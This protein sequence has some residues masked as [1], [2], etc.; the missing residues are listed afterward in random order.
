MP[1]WNS[2]M[3]KPKQAFR[4][5]I[6]FGDRNFNDS[7]LATYNAIAE[8]AAKS[9]TKP[10]YTIKTN[11][12]KMLGS[13]AFLY[14]TNLSWQPISV[15]LVDITAFRADPYNLISVGDKKILNAG[16]PDASA[17]GDQYQFISKELYGE[18][19]G[20]YLAN[21]SIQQFFYSFLSDAGYVNPNEHSSD[22][23]LQRFRKSIFKQNTIGA[24]VGTNL[25]YEENG[26]ATSQDSWN[27]IKIMELDENGL[28]IET[29]DLYNPLI[30]KVSFGELS[31]ENENL[32]EISCE[33]SYDWAQL[34]PYNKSPNKDKY[35]GQLS[36][37]QNK[38]TASIDKQLTK[39]S[40]GSS[41]DPITKLPRVIPFVNNQD[42][43]PI[44]IDVND[45]QNLA[46][47]ELEKEQ[48]DLNKKTLIEVAIQENKLEA[49]LAKR[50]QGRLSRELDELEKQKDNLLKEAS[51]QLAIDQKQKEIDA[52]TRPA[53]NAVIKR[54]ETQSEEIR[55]QGDEAVE[56]TNDSQIKRT[57][58]TPEM[59]D[60][61]RR[62]AE[63]ATKTK[64]VEAKGREVESLRGKAEAASRSS[65]LET[66]Q[67]SEDAL[68]LGR[69]ATRTSRRPVT[70][71]EK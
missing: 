6:S 61:A 36:E 10:S 8:Y 43:T 55:K 59:A 28:V 49:S 20:T 12:Y 41:I 37:V 63:E 32:V 34:S 56:K 53:I 45:Y 4:W 62:D 67:A 29:W 24:L 25:N 42:G 38:L 64:L 68:T 13:H 50:G 31:Y 26:E 23:S 1:F 52:L 7:T 15:K 48:K 51:R 47:A 3:I 30:S 27:T 5:V 46:K 44:Y 54:T 9:V 60:K 19:P 39:A 57:P 69:N 66:L 17:V 21:R 18:S 70:S 71:G 11:T 40:L 14:P 22:D 16:P 65:A 2:P 33:I 58:I 35:K